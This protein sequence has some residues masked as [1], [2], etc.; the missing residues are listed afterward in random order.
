MTFDKYVNFGFSNL[1]TP[2]PAI[3]HMP[4]RGYVFAAVRKL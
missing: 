2:E 3:T 4:V 1:S